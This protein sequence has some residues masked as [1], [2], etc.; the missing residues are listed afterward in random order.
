LVVAAEG[1][2]EVWRLAAVSRRFRARVPAL[3]ERSGVWAALGA[4]RVARRDA[5]G[6]TLLMRAAR[7]RETQRVFELAEL[8]WPRCVAASGRDGSTA[9]VEAAFRC[10]YRAVVTLLAA[11]ADANVAGARSGVSALTWACEHG[12]EAITRRLVAAGARVGAHP[13]LGLPRGGVARTPLSA[14]ASGHHASASLFEFLVER[15]RA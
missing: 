11:G 13:R 9:L 14:A 6:A 8:G 15:G 12:C 7:E 10:D 2:W 3:L 4:A 1:F 5:A